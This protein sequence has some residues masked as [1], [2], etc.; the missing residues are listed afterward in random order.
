MPAKSDLPSTSELLPKINPKTR[1][2]KNRAHHATAA[3]TA[4]PVRAH[5]HLNGAHAANRAPYE[6]RARRAPESPP[7]RV[8][9]FYPDERLAAWP[10]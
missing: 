3:R 9:E 2:M 10:K 7:K 1:E 8:D 4:T 6:T 5:L